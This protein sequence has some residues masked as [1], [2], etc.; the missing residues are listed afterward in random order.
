MYVRERVGVFI[1]SARECVGVIKRKW[2][3]GIWSESPAQTEEGHGQR[4][5][6]RAADHTR[7]VRKGV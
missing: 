2:L 6:V 4:D 3:K 5:R 7:L 1:F